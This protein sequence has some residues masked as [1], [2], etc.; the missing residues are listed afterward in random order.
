MALTDT[1][2]IEQYQDLSDAGDIEVVGSSATGAAVR[3]ED[4]PELADDN[5]SGGASD[6]RSLDSEEAGEAWKPP[7]PLPQRPR[8]SLEPGA[9]R[10]SRSLLLPKQTKALINTIAEEIFSEERYGGKNRISWNKVYEA[11]PELW[12]DEKIRLAD[13]TIQNKVKLLI[14]Q[15]ATLLQFQ[16]QHGPV[17]GSPGQRTDNEQ[18]Q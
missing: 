6:S 18:S 11:H 1:S 15:K 2:I 16:N 13:D 17:P 3:E 8:F 7:S 10:R 14:K 12:L 5:L 4:S 9:A